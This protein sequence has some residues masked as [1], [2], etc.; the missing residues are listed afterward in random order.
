MPSGKNATPKQNVGRPAKYKKQKTL[1]EK[2]DEYFDYCDTKNKDE[3]GKHIIVKPY[4]ISGLC[5]YLDIT[6]E[7]LRQYESKEEF[8]DTIKK[9]KLRIE[10]FVEESSLIGQLNP[11]VS[12]FNLKNN[13]GWKDDRGK[14]ES[15]GKTENDGF[16][17]ALTGKVDEVWQE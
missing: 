8:S 11:T 12:I 5:A 15:E 7:T 6:R 16:I 1:K 10:N 13:F 17:K 2:I 14:D 3:K 9:A 4:T